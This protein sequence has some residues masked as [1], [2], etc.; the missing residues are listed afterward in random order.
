M[1]KEKALAQDAYLKAS[2]LKTDWIGKKTKTMDYI[3]NWNFFCLG[4]IKSEAMEIGKG[5]QKYC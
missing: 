2:E 4:N 5:S 1:H 3:T